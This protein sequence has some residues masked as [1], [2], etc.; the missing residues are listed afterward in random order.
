MLFFKALSLIVNTASKCGF[1]GAY[2]PYFLSDACQRRSG[3][4]AGTESPH[5]LPRQTDRRTPV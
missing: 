3:Y 5:P 1:T 4:A 2:G